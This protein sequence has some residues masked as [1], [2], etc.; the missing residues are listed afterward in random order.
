V[1]CERAFHIETRTDAALPVVVIHD[2]IETS[3]KF[4]EFNGFPRS[5]TADL[6]ASE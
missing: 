3:S 2:L 1:L 5:V 6:S 4:Y